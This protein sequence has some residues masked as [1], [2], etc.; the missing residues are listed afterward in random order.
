MAND[1]IWQGDSGNSYRVSSGASADFQKDY[2]D[3][4]IAE[5][6]NP[7]AED[8][9]FSDGETL[10]AKLLSGELKGEPGKDGKDGKDGAPGTQGE[11][12]QPGDRGA[13][14]PA[15]VKGE[16]GDVGPAGPRGEK[17]ETGEQG[18]RG[19][20]GTVEQIPT[21]SIKENQLEVTMI[22]ENINSN[23][24][25]AEN[26]IYKTFIAT[27]FNLCFPAAGDI[28]DKTIT[29]INAYDKSCDM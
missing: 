25:L 4:R 22:N 24:N 28:K 14:G 20:P 9:T 21:H 16:K 18:P 19:I 12:G 17:G 26:K 27:D 15:G 6:H 2:V 29:V 23:F 13:Q 3:K 8:I 5:L 10:Q 7:K 1:Y 11:K